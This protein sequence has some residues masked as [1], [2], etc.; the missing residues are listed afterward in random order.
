[1]NLLTDYCK[2]FFN[3]NFRPETTINSILKCILEP[4]PKDN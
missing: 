2:D 3:T 1:M 4:I